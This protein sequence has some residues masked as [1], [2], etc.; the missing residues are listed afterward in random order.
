MCYSEKEIA[1]I[2]G[3]AR[4]N[5]ATLDNY[6]KSKHVKVHQRHGLES[7]LGRLFLEVVIHDAQLAEPRKPYEALLRLPTLNRYYSETTTAWAL[8]HLR[9][10]PLCNRLRDTRLG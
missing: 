10:Q 1:D 6:G 5:R 8:Q 2:S 3:N 4:S 9:F 7:S